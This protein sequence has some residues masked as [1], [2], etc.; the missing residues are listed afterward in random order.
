MD[1]N[2]EQLTILLKQVVARRRVL[3]GKHYSKEK[4]DEK[5]IP[6]GDTVL[7]EV[8]EIIFL[9]EFSH[10]MAIKEESDMSK[11]ELDEDVVY[12]LHEYVTCI[13]TMYRNNPFHNFEHASQ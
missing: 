5:K 1:W 4:V 13:S 7:S 12:Q 6:S 9:P 11:I 8:K 2:C 3:A 10:E